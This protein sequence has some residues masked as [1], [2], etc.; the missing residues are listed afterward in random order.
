MARSLKTLNPLAGYLVWS[1]SAW[2]GVSEA[3][4]S[5]QACLIPRVV[6]QLKGQTR[7]KA[8]SAATEEAKVES[9]SSPAAPWAS[10]S[11]PYCSAH[12][13]HVAEGYERV[14]CALRAAA[15]ERAR[16]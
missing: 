9:A 13:S 16:A 11:S 2:G 8:S 14:A 6:P 15:T 10:S 3:P 7:H 12:P 1:G 5:G 4:N